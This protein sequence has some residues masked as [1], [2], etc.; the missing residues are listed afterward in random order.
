MKEPLRRTKVVKPEGLLVVEEAEAPAKGD[1]IKAVM[2]GLWARR[3]RRSCL[4]FSSAI[5]ASVREL[6]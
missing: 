3:E 2:E 4:R 5:Q 1:T 6:T